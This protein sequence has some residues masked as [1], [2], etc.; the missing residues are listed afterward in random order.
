MGFEAFAHGRVAGE[1]F[2]ARLEAELAVR[3]EV[4]EVLKLAVPPGA[5]HLFDVETERA[6]A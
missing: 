3:L 1:P 2:V 4:G 5:V 6:L